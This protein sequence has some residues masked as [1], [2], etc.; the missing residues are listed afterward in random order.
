MFEPSTSS[1]VVRFLEA[2]KYRD[3]SS[4]AC[5]SSWRRICSSLVAE[6][7]CRDA[8]FFFSSSGPQYPVIAVK[9]QFSRPV[10]R[11]GSRQR[12]KGW[13]AVPADENDF[14]RRSWQDGA[15]AEINCLAMRSSSSLPPLA[16]DRN[17]NP[18]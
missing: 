4:S 11:D 12:V 17:G 18:P 5:R 3:K 16:V 8:G 2:P 13:G 14:C 9:A 1:G 15:G 6:I 7:L 10:S